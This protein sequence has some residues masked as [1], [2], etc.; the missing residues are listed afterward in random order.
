VA[1]HVNSS[2]QRKLVVA[3]NGLEDGGIKIPFAEEAKR[4]SWNPSSTHT[5]K[6]GDTFLGGKE[7]G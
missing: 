3:V 5:M 4:A 6:A 2:L 7:P 1:C